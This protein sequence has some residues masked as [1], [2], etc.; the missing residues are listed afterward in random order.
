MQW[1]ELSFDTTEEA[2]DWVRTLAIAAYYS[3][4]HITK[5]TSNEYGVEPQWACNIRLY[6]ANDIYATE[7]IEKI[8]NLLFPLQ[9]TGM[10]AEMERTLVETKPPQVEG[11][12]P[13]I[14]RI[15][16]R[17]VVLTPNTPYESQQEDEVILRLKTT[18]SFGSGLH[19]T[20]M[21]SLQLLERYI[22][23]AMNVLDFGAGSGILSIAMAKLG[24]SVL[25]I[26]NDDI[27]VQST[28]DA[29]Y[30]NG[31]ETQVKAMKGSLGH[32]SDLGHWLSS[33]TLDKVSTID[34][35]QTFDLIVA[36]IQARIHIALAPDFHKAL[37]RDDEY[38][39]LLI[40][41]GFTTDY[42][43]EVTTAFE[44]V[45]FEA[46]DRESLDEWVGLVYRGR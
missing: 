6:L 5:Y 33:Y 37:R 29:I 46:V 25:A 21:L 4:M 39:G 38:T 19:P 40:A 31:V 12:S 8:E 1:I 10:C 16:Q 41:A 27:A 22:V 42:E 36:N 45:G 34:I 26:D 28:Q 2:V 20:T 14:H 30:R 13:S 3:E 15:G 35:N 11:S 43:N 18:L 24:A 32:G 17:F 23:P 9:R 44:K 7:R